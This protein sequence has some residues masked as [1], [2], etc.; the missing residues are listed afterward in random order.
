MFMWYGDIAASSLADS[1]HFI[2]VVVYLSK[3]GNIKIMVLYW[4]SLV[5]RLYGDGNG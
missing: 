1:I 5:T 2:Q 3:R 4:T